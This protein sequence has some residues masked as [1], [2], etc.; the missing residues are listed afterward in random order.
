MVSHVQFHTGDLVV[1]RRTEYGRCP[2]PGAFR[3]EATPNGETYSWCIDRY[4]QILS[5]NAD[6][7]L[8]IQTGQGQ[9]HV[10]RSDDPGLRRAGFFERFRHARDF[11]RGDSS[12]ARAS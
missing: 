8:V 11:P 3:V 9:Q 6:C 7:T 12:N 4:G 2:E 1:Y 10:V 5:I